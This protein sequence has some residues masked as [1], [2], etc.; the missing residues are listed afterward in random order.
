MTR[1][2]QGIKVEVGDKQTVDIRIEE[3]VIGKKATGKL[4]NNR[5][6]FNIYSN[7]Q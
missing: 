7:K 6:L 1:R 5:R 3:V 4:I 2:L